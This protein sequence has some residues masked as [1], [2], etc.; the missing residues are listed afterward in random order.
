M[1]S[2]VTV[3]AIVFAVDTFVFVVSVVT[4]VAD[5]SFVTVAALGTT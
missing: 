4:A 3:V 5:V 1:L 2:V